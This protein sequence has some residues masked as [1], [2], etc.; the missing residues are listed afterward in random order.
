MIP[1][2]IKSK[3]SFFGE[4]EIILNKDKRYTKA[5]V[6]SEEVEVYVLNKNVNLIF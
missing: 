6:M 1:F 4:E 3:N 5:V 2:V